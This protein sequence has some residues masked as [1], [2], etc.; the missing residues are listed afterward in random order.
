MA[1]LNRR[2]FLQGSAAALAG[3]SMISMQGEAE[4]A[5]LKEAITGLAI[6]DQNGEKFNLN[7]ALQKPCIVVF[8]YGGCPLCDEITDVVAATQKKMLAKGITDVPIIIIS[9]QPEADRNEMREYVKR[10]E[11]AGVKEFPPAGSQRI[12]HV[13]CPPTARDTQ[14]LERAVAK[15]AG[16][17]TG[18]GRSTKQHSRYL[19]PCMN[20]KALPA[21]S[22][23]NGGPYLG[24]ALNENQ[25]FEADEDLVNTQSDRLVAAIQ[26]MKRPQRGQGGGN[27]RTP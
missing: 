23:A 7:L 12:L 24:A 21:P 14:D 5:S 1:Q 20:G 8:G 26:E 6:T 15:E 3:G 19:T 25:A 27:A 2:R 13:L 22:K 17:D 11:S 9:A 10:Y 4:G 18:L 16:T